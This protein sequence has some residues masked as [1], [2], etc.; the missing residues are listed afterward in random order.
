LKRRFVLNIA[1]VLTLSIGAVGILQFMLFRAEQWRLIDARIESMASLLISSD[2][3]SAELREF[4]EAEDIILRQVGGESFNQFVI[5]Y[6]RKGQEVYRSRNVGPLP[7]VI[8]RDQQW[9]TIESEG[10]LIRVLSLPLTAETHPSEKHRMLQTGL[11]LDEDLLRWKSLSR[12]MIISGALVIALIL[13]TTFL[14][15]EALLKPVASLAR[16]LRHLGTQIDAKQLV[17]GLPEAQLPVLSGKGEFVQLVNEVES[18]RHRIAGGLRNTQAWTAQMAHE[19]K[20]PLTILQNSVERARVAEK[21]AERDLALNEATSEVAHLNSLISGFLEW[22]AAENFPGGT[23]E[24]HAVR[25]GVMVSELVEKIGR[26]Y[27]ERLELEGE[28]TLTVFAKRGFVKQAI[29]NLLTNAIKYS[30]SDR[31]VRVRLGHRYL[32]IIDAGPGLPADVQSHLG[33]P[34]NYGSTENHGFGLGLAWVNT[35]CHKYGWELSFDRVQEAGI[36]FTVA[37]IIFPEDSP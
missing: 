20:T 24:L 35:I 33:R 27:P 29:S 15:T 31:P 8:P 6:N 18:L 37:K 7:D 13:L 1:L 30:P 4:E 10:R 28:S 16:Y 25:L 11:V 32:S 2:L 26:Q 19:M 36:E 23:E 22:T 17:T 9:Q 12:Q 21:Q 14:L 3:S 34:F 5:I